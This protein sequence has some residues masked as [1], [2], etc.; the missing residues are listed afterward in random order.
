MILCQIEVIYFSTHTPPAEIERLTSY[1]FSCFTRFAPCMHIAD[2]LPAG[3]EWH[4]YDSEYESGPTVPFPKEPPLTGYSTPKQPPCSDIPCLGY[5][6]GRPLRSAVEALSTKIA[7]VHEEYG[8]YRREVAKVRIVSSLKEPAPWL[9][10]AIVST[11]HAFWAKRSVALQ[12]SRT[13]GS[14]KTIHRVCHRK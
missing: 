7:K 13:P 9:P 2:L 6:T 12:P 8:D 1:N 10:G 5:G 3:K 11:D 4:L 14:R